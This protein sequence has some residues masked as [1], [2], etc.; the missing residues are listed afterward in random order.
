MKTPEEIKKG[1]VCCGVMTAR[2]MPCRACPY[3]DLCKEK[4]DECHLLPDALAYIVLLE[5][6]LAKRDKLLAVMGVKVPEGNDHEK[7][8]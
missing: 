7:P 4:P 5:E 2:E 8:V 1:L 6:R 3:D